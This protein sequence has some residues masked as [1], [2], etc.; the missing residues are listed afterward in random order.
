MTDP[1]WMASSDQPLIRERF[2]EAVFL[3]NPQ[4]GETHVLNDMALSILELLENHPATLDEILQHHG[5]ESPGASCGD[6]AGA[7]RALLAELD[8]QG[9]IAPATT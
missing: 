1:A 4:S 7:I 9:L 5:I 2:E 6:V 8:R 3:F